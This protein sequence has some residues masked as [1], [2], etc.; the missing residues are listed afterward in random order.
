MAFPETAS[1]M[2]KAHLP[3]EELGPAVHL[4]AGCSSVQ[5]RDP[6]LVA[7]VHFG[8]PVEVQKVVTSTFQFQQPLDN[9]CAVKQLHPIITDALTSDSK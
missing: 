7:D 3:R 2:V 9:H 4:H 8:P 1:C 6:Q 5:A